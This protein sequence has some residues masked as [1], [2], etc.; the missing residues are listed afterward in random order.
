MDSWNEAAG[1][2]GVLAEPGGSSWRTSGAR[3]VREE[4]DEATGR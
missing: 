2:A 1:L 3:G 4:F